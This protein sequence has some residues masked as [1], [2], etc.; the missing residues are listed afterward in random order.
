M[1]HPVRLLLLAGTA[2]GLS[3]GLALAQMEAPP[4]PDLFGGPG[5]GRMSERF[6]GDFDANH[7]GKVTRDEFNA[8]LAKKYD[9]LAGK[10]G[11]VTLDAFLDSHL[12]DI[13][14]YTDEMFRRADWNNDGKLSLEE[15]SIAPKAKFMAADKDGLGAI[16]CAPHH[17]GGP[18]MQHA[19]AEFAEHHPMMAAHW[20]GMGERCQ[21]AD[22]NHD[23]KVT[24]GEVDKAIQAKFTQTAKGASGITRDEFYSFELSRL[25]EAA[26][27]RFDRADTNH[28]GKL[29]KAEF[30]APAQ[31]MFDHL[32]RNKDGVITADELKPH[33]HGDWHHGAGRKGPGPD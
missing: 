10:N 13:R 28:D 24:R 6:L 21:E 20:R 2:L 30:A 11:G 33:R 18:R 19:K 17:R 22:L 26:K 5:H 3:T 23:G 4:A 15:F 29:S 14:Q 27:K 32:D 1:K 7:D 16:S 8:G 12:K 25:R 31:K 9:R